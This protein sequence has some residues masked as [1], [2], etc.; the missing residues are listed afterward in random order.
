ML[1][2]LDR[3]QEREFSVSPRLSKETLNNN[4]Y[5][6][7]EVRLWDWRALEAVYK[8]FQEIRLYYEFSDVD[9]D[10][11]QTTQ[12]YRQVMVAAREMELAN[13]PGESQTFVN[14]RF[15]Y[16]HGYGLVMS[17][18]S[19]FT[20]D[21]LPNFLIKDIPPRTADEKLRVAQPTDLLRRADALP[22]VR[23]YQ[24]ARI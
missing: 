14:L 16:T 15:K 12:G 19:D 13:L 8:Q 4:K 2:S 24:G 18:V 23:Q 11:Y 5:L 6:L 22:C 9:V 10:R 17:P 21:G 1:F 20:A 7:S 3:V